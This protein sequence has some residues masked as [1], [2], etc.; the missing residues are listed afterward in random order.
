MT[1]TKGHE[2]GGECSGDMNDAGSAAQLR[3]HLRRVS[4]AGDPPSVITVSQPSL[5]H[6][7][8]QP[9]GLYSNSWKSM[10]CCKPE[11]RKIYT[12]GRFHVTGQTQMLL[13]DQSG[14]PMMRCI[15]SPDAVIAIRSESA[16]ADKCWYHLKTR[17]DAL[18]RVSEYYGLHYKTPTRPEGILFQVK[19]Q[20]FL[21]SFWETKYHITFIDRMT[22]RNEQLV[23]KCKKGDTV[24]K[25]TMGNL[26]IGEIRHS[27]FRIGELVS[28]Q[29]GHTVSL[30]IHLSSICPISILIGKWN[31]GKANKPHSV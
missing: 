30:S 20:S 16:P 13:S 24:A 14:V 27:D 9:F 23:L 6:R 2:I 3:A 12:H 7:F 31:E 18:S 17:R 19:R 26:L 1:P 15:R 5:F 10:E 4:I 22:K 25:L 29:G 11:V 28:F 21:H 8:T